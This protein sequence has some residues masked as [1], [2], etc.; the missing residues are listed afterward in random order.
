MT[1]APRYRA[2]VSYSHADAAVAQWLHRA[3]ETYRMPRPL[4]ADG[5][6]ARLFPVFRDRSDL[7]AGADL[8][9][10]IR[11]AL[12]ASDALIVVCSPA[13]ARS[14]YVELEIQAFV[15]AYPERPVLAVIAVGDPAPG[16]PDR[17][18]PPALTEGGR[19]PIAADLR[20][21]GDGRRMTLLKLV[22]GLTGADLVRLA[23]R[24]DLRRIRRLRW[25]FAAALVLLS[26]L[27]LLLWQAVLARREA[28]RQRVAAETL[29]EFMVG[30]LRQRLDPIGKLSILDAVARRALAYYQSQ[31]GSGLAPAEIAQRARVLRMI[32]EIDDKQGD[33]PRAAS[34]FAEAADA[35]G[36][37]LALAPGD[38]ERIFDHAQS[39]YF[40]GMVAL[41]Q[42]RL[43]AAQRAFETYRDLAVRLVAIG[44]GRPEWQAELGYAYSNIG[45][46]LMEL[47][48]SRA[49]EAAFRQ[50]LTISEAAARTTPG[51]QQ[52]LV[53]LA[54]AHAWLADALER[55]DAYP[56]AL[57]QR[58]AELAIDARLLAAAPGDTGLAY[59]RNN[60]EVSRAHVL[61]QLGR[62]AE[63]S[64]A[65]RLAL[66]HARALSNSDPLNA[67]W[68]RQVAS[69][70]LNAGTLGVA[71][72]AIGQAT[73]ALRELDAL[74][75]ALPAGR[76]HAPE[77]QVQ[78]ISAAFLRAKIAAAAG[79]PGEA[80][81]SARQALALASRAGPAKSWN[82][83]LLRNRIRVLLAQ[84]LSV[85][86]QR[87]EAVA[88]AQSIVSELSA[89]ET[90][91]VE[92]NALLDSA[93]KLLLR[94]ASP[95]VRQGEFDAH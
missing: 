61:G 49:A 82:N 6:P 87:G 11:E 37:L 36:R 54:Q 32:G 58:D 22:A 57:Q 40:V 35:T 17:C 18:F 12:L 1:A 71:S 14:R 84:Q 63:A 73:F 31:K 28:E 91:N 90:G 62:N 51:A 3:L 80:I 5:L 33:L 68:I 55:Q 94:T 89:S 19:E 42:R 48:R 86:R 53:D 88:V 92:I 9:A 83:M 81:A 56:A 43:D 41:E 66:D 30:D 65:A 45:T 39:V 23:R 59:V 2:F 7:R 29:V 75:A 15:A 64:R 8:G 50:V 85:A 79:R 52:T 78:R 77:W 72:G 20:P 46:V 60:G 70:L 10:S 27:G 44:P 16:A 69:C 74:L 38:G 25:L 67:L 13:A 21:G 4:I 34:S 76:L 93:R 26:V 24:D 47:G 95:A